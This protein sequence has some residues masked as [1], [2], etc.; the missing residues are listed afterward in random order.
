MNPRLHRVAGPRTGLLLV[1]FVAVALLFPLASRADAGPKPSMTFT[2][3]F[4][5][6]PVAI[7]EAQMLECED[8]AC[9]RS[10][11]L[12]ELGP[13]GFRCASGECTSTAYGYAPYHKLVIRFDDGTR[14]SNVFGKRAFAARYRVTVSDSGLEVKEVYGPLDLCCPVNLCLGSSLATILLETLVAGA[15]LAAFRVPRAFLGWVPLAS[16]FTLPV[17]WL[18]APQAGSNA[19]LALGVA[20]AF[21]VLFEGGFVYVMGRRAAPLKHILAMSLAMNTASFAVGLLL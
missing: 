5:G 11:P 3:A 14:E 10:K 21:A 19:S 8:A 16:L 7:V 1:A 12:P 13:Q 15:Y 17:V 9:T 18:L 4:P 2:F 20:E 6:E